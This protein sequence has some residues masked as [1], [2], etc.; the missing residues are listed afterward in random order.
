M[1]MSDSSSGS[2]GMSQPDHRSAE[3]REKDRF[4]ADSSFESNANQIRD[5]PMPASWHDDDGRKAAR[6]SG[7]SGDGDASPA[8]QVQT[9]GSEVNQE[10]SS[11]EDRPPDSRKK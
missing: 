2:R 5:E 8:G 6:Q 3:E 7:G 9:A 11:R 1:I 4:E 10:R